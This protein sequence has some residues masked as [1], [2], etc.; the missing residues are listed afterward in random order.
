MNSTSGKRDPIVIQLRR[1]PAFCY[2]VL[3]SASA[4]DSWSLFVIR[5]YGKEADVK[6][7]TRFAR[8]KPF[9]AAGDMVL[10]AWV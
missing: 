5:L 8:V 1:T 9:N 10:T 3:P 4:C 6:K 2:V 7:D